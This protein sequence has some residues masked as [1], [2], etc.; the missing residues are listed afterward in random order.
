VLQAAG[1]LGHLSAEEAKDVRAFLENP[2][3][4]SAAHG[5]KTGKD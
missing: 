3:A 1:D 5:G 2:E 4:W